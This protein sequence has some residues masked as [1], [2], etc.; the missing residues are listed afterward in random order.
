MPHTTTSLRDFIAAGL[1]PDSRSENPSGIGVTQYRGMKPTPWGARPYEA[2]TVPISGAELTA[3]GVTIAHPFPQMFRGKGVTLLCDDTKIFTV[4]ETTFTL[5]LISTFDP[6][7]PNNSKAIPSGGGSWQFA[8]FHT[9]WFLFK[10]NITVFQTQWIDPAK[11]FA[12][13]AVTIITGCD[14]RGSMIRGG[15]DSD[16]W[17]AAWITQFDALYPKGS[18]DFGFGLVQPSRNWIW[19]S[20]IGGGDFVQQFVPALAIDDV[21]SITGGNDSTTPLLDFQLKRA[22]SGMMPMEFQGTVVACVP[23]RDI[24]LICGTDGIN[25]IQHFLEPIPGFGLRRV[26]DIGIASRNAIG[27]DFNLKIFIDASGVLWSITNDLT[28]TRLGYEEFFAPMVGNEIIISH[29]PDRNEF[30]ISDATL[31]FLFNEQGLCQIPQLVSSVFQVNGV[32]SGIV[33]DAFDTTNLKID[34]DTTGFG[35]N[36]QKTIKR[37]E[38]IHDGTTSADLKV[39]VKVRRG[40]SEAFVDL[41]AVSVDEAGIYEVNATGNEFQVLLSETDRTRVTEVDDV[42]LVF[43]DGAKMNLKQLISV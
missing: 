16:F 24:V 29:D 10:S 4:D 34:F 14:F 6:V 30:Y 1:R 39:Q 33:S 2:I 28:L 27:G 7:I 5:T 8:D 17:S 37:V 20:L 35:T 38:V 41:T 42:V 32:L 9:T 13:D 43:D 21:G 18:V 23:F 31:S 11:V 12:Q 36:V 40:P 26:L 3:N 19:W 15:F 25:A 22:S